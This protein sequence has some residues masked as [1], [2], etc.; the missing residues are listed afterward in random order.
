LRFTFHLLTIRE[1]SNR[2]SQLHS[3]HMNMSQLLTAKALLA[4]SIALAAAV[5]TAAAEGPDRSLARTPPMGWN[6]WNTFAD[7][8]DEAQIRQMADVMVSSGMRDAGYVYLNLDDNWMADTRDTQG[9]LRADPVKFPSGLKAL[10]DYIH[11]KG[12]KFGIYGDRG[13]A[14]CA[15][16]AGS[17]SYGHEEQDAR[18][19]AS[20]GVDYLKYDNC[21]V[22]TRS[23]SDAMREDFDRMGR[24]LRATGRPIVYSICAWKLRGHESWMPASGHVWRTTGDIRPTWA[25]PNPQRSVLAIVDEHVGLE[26]HQR[27]GGWND[28]DMLEVGV[29][30]PWYDL[31]KWHYAVL[32]ETEA[33]SHFALWAMF[34][35][36]LFAGNDL[37]HMSRATHEL[38]THRGLIAID[39]DP[40]GIQARRVHHEAGGTDLFLKPLANGDVAALLL[41]RADTP[42]TLALGW[43]RQVKAVQDVLAQKPLLAGSGEY[44][45]EVAAHGVMVLRLTGVRPE[46]LS[47]R[48]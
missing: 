38:L 12:L 8:I 24:A 43:P 25:E 18:T 2:Y 37:R 26:E 1:V 11:S 32:N 19:F 45:A 15:G 10:A 21:N 6:T 4:S 20:W 17:G 34:S 36:P 28:P 30:A 9:N 44:R 48:P 27:P 23:T 47:L 42:R 22:G 14:T 41:N 5:S 13:S 31:P 46:Q 29:P 16:P 3:P 39:Q 33:Q 35:A 40:L 7:R